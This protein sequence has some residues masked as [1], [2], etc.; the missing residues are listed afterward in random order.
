VTI[1]RIE[2]TPILHRTV[3]SGETLHLSGIV[4]ADESASM[5]VQTEQI[6]DRLEA[7]LGQSGSDLDHVLSA[8]IFITDMAQ[9]DAMNEV[10]KR[11][12]K[13]EKLPARTTVGV[14]DL[15]SGYLIEVTATAVRA[16]A[17]ASSKDM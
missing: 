16:S 9:K 7:I 17:Q 10:W 8:Q 6:L 11:R 3:A 15:G 4:A 5:A 13:P 1:Q 12:F 2:R 14:A